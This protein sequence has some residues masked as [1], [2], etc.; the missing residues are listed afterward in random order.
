MPSRRT[1]ALFAAAALAVAA[2]YSPASLHRSGTRKNRRLKLP[3][4]APLPSHTIAP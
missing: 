1:N 4:R 2:A 3:V